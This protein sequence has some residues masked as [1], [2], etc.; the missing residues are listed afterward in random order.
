MGLILFQV[1]QKD[2]KG[3]PLNAPVFYPGSIERTSFAE[4][5]EPK[6]YLILEFETGGASTGTLRIWTFQ[7]LPARPMNQ[8]DLHTAAMTGPQ[9]QS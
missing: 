4:K 2:L 7:E 3:M 5:D 8:L 9:I 1:L 6:G